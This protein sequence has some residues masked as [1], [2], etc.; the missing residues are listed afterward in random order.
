M[1]GIFMV[2]SNRNDRWVFPGSRFIEGL[3]GKGCGAYSR[4]RGI[5]LAD[6]SNYSSSHS[7]IPIGRGSR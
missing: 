6:S 1:N 7:L 2:G 4:S 3:G 5:V